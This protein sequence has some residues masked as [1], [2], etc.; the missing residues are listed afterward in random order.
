MCPKQNESEWSVVIHQ[1][2]LLCKY[3]AKVAKGTRNKIDT[4][5]QSTEV[6]TQIP[7]HMQEEIFQITNHF[8]PMATRIECIRHLQLATKYHRKLLSAHQEL[9]KQS[10]LS[11]QE[12]RKSEGNLEAAEIILKILRHETHNKD[13]AILRALRHPKISLPPSKQELYIKQ[14]QTINLAFH[15]P[16]RS[17]LSTINVPHLDIDRNPMNHPDKAETSSTISDPIEIEDRILARNIAHFGQAQGI[18]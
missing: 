3:W 2:S 10:L 12:A 6:F 18:I 4:S 11:L 14:W 7:G 17:S 15:P 1:Q 8:H 5:R 16:Q 13:L 9:R